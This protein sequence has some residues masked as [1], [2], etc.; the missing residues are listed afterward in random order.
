MSALYPLKFEAIYK[1]KIW[2][3]EKLNQV[4]G[5][6][7]PEGS[8]GESWEI[9]AVKDNISVASNGYLAGNSLQDLIEIYMGD[10]LGDKVYKKYGI[11]FPLL[12]KYIDASDNL[13]IQVH[14][15]DELAKKRHNA[16]GKTEMW[17][18]IAAEKGAKLISGFNKEVTK[19]EYLDYLEKGRLEELVNWEPVEPGSV[20]FMPSGRI[21]AIGAGI[22]L[23]EIQQTSDITYRI[24]DWNRK[25]KNGNTRELHTDLALDAIDF[26]HYD[27]YRTEYEAAPD[28]ASKIIKCPYF[29]TQ[30]I[31]TRDMLERNYNKLD[32]FVIY[33]CLEGEAILHYDMMDEIKIRTGETILIPASIEH[34]R[35]KAVKDLKMLEVFIDDETT[36]DH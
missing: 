35:I 17:Y 20:F 23:A 6:E 12:I 8:I 11:E 5:K 26:K 31:Q 25:D 33:M 27:S 10:L 13:S 4:L 16:Y 2:G 18:V 9:S 30:L 32:S 29:T 19:G 14:P 22:V 7:L 36:K 3:G 34:I 1:P 15:N 28:E 21:H 24:Y